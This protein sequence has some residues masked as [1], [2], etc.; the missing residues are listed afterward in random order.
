MMPYHS[1]HNFNAKYLAQRLI[2]TDTMFRDCSRRRTARAV[3]LLSR[4]SL[5]PVS[6]E[7]TPAQAYSQDSLP[8]ALATR[9]R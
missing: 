9:L 4:V 8:L 7:N 1:D 5:R 2:M 3:R 6:D